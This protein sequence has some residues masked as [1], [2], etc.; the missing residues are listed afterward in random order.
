MANNL[1]NR[2]DKPSWFFS[3]ILSTIQRHSLFLDTIVQPLFDRENIFM[4]TKVLIIIIKSDL[5]NILI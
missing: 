4:N 3:N 5:L 1:T 2:L